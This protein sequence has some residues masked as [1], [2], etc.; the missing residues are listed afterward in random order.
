M[1]GATWGLGTILG[2]IVGGAFT[3]SAAGWRWAF[4]INLPMG[5]ITIPIL[6][7]LIPSF[8]L[9][10]GKTIR[11]RVA[12]IDWIGS[13]LFVGAIV[14]LV[15]AIALGGNEFAW[16]S[17]QIIGLFIVFGCLFMDV[18]IQVSFSPFSFSVKRCICHIRLSNGGSSQSTYSFCVLPY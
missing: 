2:P 10:K 12:Q 15:V 9:Q 11:E 4:Y 8:D 3:D 5:A 18:L 17:T 16:N 7:I 1:T 14:S 6:A 13:I